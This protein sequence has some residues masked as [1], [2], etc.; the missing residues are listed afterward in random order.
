MTVGYGDI[1]PKSRIG[2]I[3]TV[4]LFFLVFLTVSWTIGTLALLLRRVQK[5]VNKNIAPSDHLSH[6]HDFHWDTY[7]TT[8]IYGLLWSFTV[9]LGIFIYV[10]L[11]GNLEEDGAVLSVYWVITTITTVGYGD[12]EISEEK[13][14]LIVCFYICMAVPITALL[15]NSIVS[16]PINIESRYERSDQ[17]KNLQ[18]YANTDNSL[19]EAEFLLLMLSLQNH[20]DQILIQNRRKMFHIL[21]TAMGREYAETIRKDEWIQAIKD[22]I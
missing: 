8:Y 18:V 12:I 20:V 2:R 4:L 19:H 3:G 14:K 10:S 11:I 1:A 9:I 15:F 5:K 17:L 22:I 6:N 13:A 7:K 21:L 16:I